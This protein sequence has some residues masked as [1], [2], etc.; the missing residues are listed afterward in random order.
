[1][2][3]QLLTIRSPTLDSDVAKMDYNHTKNRYVNILAGTVDLHIHVNV[4]FVS[5]YNC[6]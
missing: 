5:K 3:L 1:M 6:C 2:L 4:Q